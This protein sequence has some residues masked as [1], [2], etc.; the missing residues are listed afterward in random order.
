[1]SEDSFFFLLFA[2][3]IDAECSPRLRVPPADLSLPRVP[4]S[5]CSFFRL[6]WL[7][8][9]AEE[10]PLPRSCKE[11]TREGNRK[12]QTAPRFSCALFLFRRSIVRRRRRLRR[13]CSPRP[14]LKKK[15]PTLPKTD[16][17]HPPLHPL[18]R[19]LE[20]SGKQRRRARDLRRG[21]GR[22]DRLSELDEDPERR[23]AHGLQESGGGGG[24]KRR[25]LQRRRPFLL[26]V[27]SR[28]A[29]P[30]V[31]RDLQL[32]PGIAQG[33]SPRLVEHRESR[34]GPLRDAGRL[35]GIFEAVRQRRPRLFDRGC[36]C[37]LCCFEW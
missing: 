32:L 18:R 31:R 34:R 8:R 7:A 20:K 12:G 16:R 21:P 2:E 27:V 5:L 9:G 30:S 17:R 3:S 35:L 6:S 10:T 4:L 1:M 36:E 24:R 26:L 15:T 33:A 14:L 19:R 25:R 13:R 22:G 23:R 37:C 28:G 29:L 11:R